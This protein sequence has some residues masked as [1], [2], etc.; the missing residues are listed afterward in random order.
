M[1]EQNKSYTEVLQGLLDTMNAKDRSIVRTTDIVSTFAYLIGVRKSIFENPHEAPDMEIF[2]KLEREKA[3]RII[4]NL[5]IIRTSIEHNFGK[6]TQPCGISS[7][8]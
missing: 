7:G 4:R 1:A 2:K 6:S 5:C 8:A 3:A